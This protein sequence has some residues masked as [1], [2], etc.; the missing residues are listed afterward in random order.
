M[1]QRFGAHGRNSVATRTKSAFSATHRP[2]ALGLAFNYAIWR[3]LAQ[4][5]APIPQPL[6]PA[7]I[8]A[9]FLVAATGALLLLQNGNTI[10]ECSTRHRSRRRSKNCLGR[11]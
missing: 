10:K 9:D 2:S 7:P 3:W 1:Y 6:R 11:D 5:P 8:R 4:G